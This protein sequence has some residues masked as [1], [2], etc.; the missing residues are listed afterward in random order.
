MNTEEEKQDS[1]DSPVPDQWSATAEF[2]SGFDR[3]ELATKHW[4]SVEL[5]ARGAP[6][7]LGGHTRDYDLVK[8]LQ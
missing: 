8:R 3:A 1:T 4:D 6:A 2:P 5:P 7:E